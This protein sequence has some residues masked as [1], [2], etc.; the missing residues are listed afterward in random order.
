[1]LWYAAGRAGLLSSEEMELGTS[2]VWPHLAEDPHTWSQRNLPLL[3][4][5]LSLLLCVSHAWVCVFVRLFSNVCPCGT[6]A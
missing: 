1:M 6:R 5:S 4:L 3:S 2:S